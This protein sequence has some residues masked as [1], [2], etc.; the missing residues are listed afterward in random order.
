M[1]RILFTAN[2]EAVLLSSF[3]VTLSTTLTSPRLVAS[4]YSAPKAW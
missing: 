4:G 3:I 1:G 2:S